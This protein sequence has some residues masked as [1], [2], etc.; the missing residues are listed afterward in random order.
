MLLGV[1]D[2][3]EEVASGGGG[4]DGK[5]FNWSFSTPTVSNA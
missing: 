3:N 1:V 2:W 5:A 4:D